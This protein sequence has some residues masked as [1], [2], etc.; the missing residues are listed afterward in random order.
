MLNSLILSAQQV[1]A[2]TLF[3]LTVGLN[4]PAASTVDITVELR[5]QDSAQTEEIMLSIGRREQS[6]SLSHTLN[7][8]GE[9]QVW[10]T[11]A[12]FQYAVTTLL[13]PLHLDLE[14]RVLAEG[15]ETTL[16]VSIPGSLME[17]Q[18]LDVLLS[19]DRVEGIEFPGANAVQLT[20]ETRSQT[21]RVRAID[22]AIAEPRQTVTITARVQNIA[23]AAEVERELEIARN[24]YAM[25][26]LAVQPYAALASDEPAAVA[27]LPVTVVLNARASAVG[28]GI[29]RAVPVS[30]A[31]TAVEE[32]FTILPGQEAFPVSLMLDAQGVYTVSATRVRFTDTPVDAD[33]QLGIGVYAPAMTVEV[34]PPLNLEL[35]LDPGIIA[36]G[37]MS[38]L[39][40]SVTGTL[41]EV[42][43]E[44]VLV[45]ELEWFPVEQVF[46]PVVT[47]PLDNDRRSVA[48]QLGAVDD[49][50][51][52]MLEEVSIH[53]W[54][55]Y[56]AGV[57]NDIAL[58]IEHNDYALSRFE[59]SPRVLNIDPVSGRATVTITVGLNAV[60]SSAAGVPEFSWEVRREGVVPDTDSIRFAAVPAGSDRFSFDFALP[61]AGTYTLSL[62]R[63]SGRFTMQ[64]AGG[65]ATIPVPLTEQQ[66]RVLPPVGLRAILEAPAAA[67]EG[68]VAVNL[69]VEA[70][71][72]VPGTTL[73]VT[74][75]A[76]PPDE[77]VFTGGAVL[78]LAESG[79]RARVTV[80]VVAVD[81]SEV[82]L[83]E[84]VEIRAVVSAGPQNVPVAT[85]TLV[86]GRSDYAVESL[87]A[88]PSRL[89]LGTAT[90][91]TAEITV[92][93]NAP[94]PAAVQ[95][96]L[97]ATEEGESVVAETQTGMIG[98]SALETTVTFENFEDATT[99]TVTITQAAF[100]AMEPQDQTDL[101]LTAPSLVLLA[102]LDTAPVLDLDINR[103]ESGTDGVTAFDLLGLYAVLILPNQF[104]SLFDDIP[105]EDNRVLRIA[106]NFDVDNP[107]ADAGAAQT[108]YDN[109]VEVLCSVPRG[110]I[111]NEFARP[112][113]A[114]CQRLGIARG[115]EGTETILDINRLE[116]GTD[117]V[118]AFD[119]LG[120][121]A[122][123][124]L[125]NQF[126]SLF[127]DI[128]L[129]DNRVLRIAINFDVDN[130]IADA[131]AAQTYYDN[132]V[133]VLCSVPRG[134]IVNE[135]ARPPDE[136]CD[137]VGITRPAAP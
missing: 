84:S 56:V 99:Y 21:V 127:D 129:E 20:R 9:Y 13:P 126:L 104:L 88:E 33:D 93:L 115:R 11:G 95:L 53:A 41:P 47:I 66:L 39:I 34:L 28:E 49:S 19:L 10:V 122:V 58:Q 35:A 123:L 12:T 106:I 25:V 32:N 6:G 118:T 87:E 120:L 90:S 40:V 18:T 137:R 60:P 73:S 1:V 63:G 94:A 55:R 26:G 57:E 42:F 112:P 109:I 74:L 50:D 98:V 79:S 83:R 46:L 82:E 78:E 29:V 27:E 65:Q 91:A 48:V 5:H 102:A 72:L 3:M 45:V 131:G 7:D 75:S 30:G 22:D 92:R 116:S 86:I 68:G 108:Y 54:A 107:I 128:P 114:E 113:D 44:R 67:S 31:G 133:E 17:G 81:D 135:F 51:A 96:S 59:V 97:T 124:I 14:R 64:S 111:V 23:G 101:L 132:I 134:S 2:G 16:T 24:D 76:E 125:P 80:P 89:L 62:V 52:E 61:E 38:T 117:G 119:L 8:A 4:G 103:L 121:Y 70:E 69:V 100:T 43:G 15:E 71:N 36:E 105:L 130:P 37:E 136:E 110:S 77:V 85:A